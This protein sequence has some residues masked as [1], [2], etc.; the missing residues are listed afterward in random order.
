MKIKYGF[1]TDKGLVRPNNEDCFVIDD[2]INLVVVADGAGG[3]ATGEV[4]SRVSVEVIREQL[5]RKISSKT[6]QSELL[7]NLESSIKFANQIVYEASKKYPQNQGMATTCV[8]VLIGKEKFFYCNVGDSRLYLFRDNK[9]QLLTTDHSLVME[10]VKKGLITE[11]QAE[12][13]EYRNILTRAIGVSE[14]VEV[15]KNEIEHKDGDYLLLCT[16]GLTRM[17]DEKTISEVLKKMDEPQKICD[18]LVDLANKNGGRDNIT[19]VIAK[20]QKECQE[21]WLDK[22]WKSIKR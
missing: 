6:S 8:A 20:I 19:V 17:V 2:E 7:S 21:N 1:K 14:N 15:D 10:Q 22:F 9:L 13:S 11:E 5:K 18:N 16:D 12:K 4:A 3:Q